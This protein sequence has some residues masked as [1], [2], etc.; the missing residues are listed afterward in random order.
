MPPLFERIESVGLAHFSYV[1]AADGEAVV[2]DPR[3]DVDAYV[4][5]TARHGMR[6]A[7]VLETHRHEDF[8]LGSVELAERTGARIWH[9]DAGETYRYGEA[10][11]PRQRWRIGDRTLEALPTPGHTAGHVAYVLR[12]AGGTPEML[13]SGDALMAGE[14]GRTDLAGDERAEEAAEQLHQSL[15]RVIL[16]LGDGVLLCPAHGG[17]SACG[18]AIADRPWTTLG[19]EWRLSPKL[20][21]RRDE[22]VVL[23]AEQSRALPVPPYFARMREANLDPPRMPRPAEP[24]PL[25]PAEFAARAEDGALVLDTRS[26]DCFAAAHVPRSL[27]IQLD[28]IGAWAGWMLDADSPLLLVTEGADASEAVRQLVRLGFDR[29]AG[30]LDGGGMMRWLTSGHPGSEYGTPDAREL[31]YWLSGSAEEAERVLGDGGCGRGG[32]GCGHGH[33]GAGVHVLDVR[34]TAELEQSGVIGGA[35]HIP[36]HELRARIG[37]VPRDR[38]VTVVCSTGVRSMT[39]ASLLERAG[40]CE[41]DVMLGGMTAWRALDLPVERPAAAARA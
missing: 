10:V 3:R 21:L 17:G 22:F 6:V 34:R 32:C 4:E 33:A 15:Q 25:S 36:L 35:Q 29:I 7:H 41:L 28:E 39:G 20:S 18:A 11:E 14:L 13:F 23:H 31:F 9:A 30:V 40:R 27:F 8:V 5:L 38:P 24:E 37:E 19:L 12:E 26:K 1:L 2:I 16:P